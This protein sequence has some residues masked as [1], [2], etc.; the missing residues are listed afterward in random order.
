MN[1]IYSL[2]IYFL[3]IKFTIIIT[4]TLKKSEEKQT[5]FVTHNFQNKE[6]KNLRILEYRNLKVKILV[7]NEFQI[8]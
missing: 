5:I 6:V 2:K 3:L 7:R 4:H 1:N 8:M